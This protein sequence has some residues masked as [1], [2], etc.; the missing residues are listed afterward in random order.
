MRMSGSPSSRVTTSFHSAA[1]N[2]VAKPRRSR[3]SPRPR[4]DRLSFVL[5]EAVDHRLVG[6]VDDPAL[7]LQRGSQ[8][9]TLHREV[10][11][12][13]ADLLRYLVPRQAF[14]LAHDF[15]LHLGANRGHREELSAFGPDDVAK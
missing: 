13:Q 9:A 6:F 2:P 8:L 12:E 14:D 15:L 5:I 7:H 4:S 3:L 1:V 10:L 11:F